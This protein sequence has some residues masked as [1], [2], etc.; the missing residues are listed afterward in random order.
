MARVSVVTLLVGAT[1]LVASCGGQA[2]ATQTSGPAGSAQ[3]SIQAASSLPST[4]S[5][6][7][8]LPGIVI[9][10]TIK[11]VTFPSALVAID[12][13]VWALGH[14]DAKWSRI[15]PA[16]DTITAT[17]ALGG[18]YATGGVLANKNLWALDFTDQQ[19]V[20]VDPA[21][22]KV[23]ATIPVGLDGRWLVGDN[24]AL[25]AIGNDAHE[26]L[27]IDPKTRAVTRLAVEPAC[28]S[29]PL[30]AGGFVWLVSGSGHLCKLDPKTGLVVGELDGLGAAQ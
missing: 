17:V 15:D 26:L 20:A 2:S 13:A 19:V 5:A 27:R 7:A 22:R 30:A 6:A 25:W 16:T 28:G 29:T 14:T 18:S 9:Q 8:E 21:T 3:A 1:L 12:G 23:A 10:A 24:D 4:S 11:G